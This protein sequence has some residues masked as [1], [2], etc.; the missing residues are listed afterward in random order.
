MHVS[1]FAFSLCKC[2]DIQ[3]T[4]GHAEHQQQR[5]QFLQSFSCRH[6][7]FS[8]LKSEDRIHGSWAGLAARDWDGLLIPLPGSAL[9]PWLCVPPFPAV[10]PCIYSAEFL[11]ILL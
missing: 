9:A 3:H 7:S 2:G 10:C 8:F 6:F 5:K 1:F 4:H 11:R